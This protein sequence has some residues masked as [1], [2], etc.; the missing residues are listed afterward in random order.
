MHDPY[1]RGR[2]SLALGYDYTPAALM[3]SV[4]PGWNGWDL[5]NAQYGASG[6]GTMERDWFDGV[7]SLSPFLVALTD[8]RADR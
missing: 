4:D 8:G 5:A 7:V 1:T 6:R 3:Y 2:R